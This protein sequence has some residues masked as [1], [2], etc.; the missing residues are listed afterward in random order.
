[1]DDD[2]ARVTATVSGWVQ[3]I[4]FRWSTMEMARTMDLVGLA[5]NLPDGDVRVVVE[6]PRWA[7]R[8]LV[9]WLYGAG[10][11]TVHRPG[12]VDAVDVVWGPAQGTFG[13]FT[14]R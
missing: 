7:C 13:S 10:P 8:T 11:Q 4:G 12:R 2:P 5:Q 6:G 3:G 9:E 14:C 1:M